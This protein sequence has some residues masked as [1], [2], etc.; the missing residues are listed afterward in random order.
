MNEQ[1]RT[2]DAADD[3]VLDLLVDGEL[4]DEQTRWLLAALDESSDGWRRCA[5]SFVEAQ[6]WGRDLGMIRETSLAGVA[7]PTAHSTHAGSIDSKRLL[8]LLLTAAASVLIA[9]AAGIGIGQ[10]WRAEIL[11]PVA[12]PN[13]SAQPEGGVSLVKTAPP[14]TPPHSQLLSNSNSDGKSFQLPVYLPDQVSEDYLR[15]TPPPLSARL[16]Q[17]LARSGHEATVQRELIPV[18]LEDG[19]QVIVPVDQVQLR[20]V[21]LAHQ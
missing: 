7:D 21:G 5:L 14:K 8:P 20:Y 17:A 13:K 6:S 12:E 4:T 10:S 2:L 19:N 11:E 16:R 3:A 9:L 15:D 1:D 18:Q